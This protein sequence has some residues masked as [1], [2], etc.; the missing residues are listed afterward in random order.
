MKK[1]VPYFGAEAYIA[2]WGLNVAGDQHSS[3][4]MWVQ[5]GP[6]DQLNVILAGWTVNF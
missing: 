2:G 4:N 5:N 1:G 3:T 6:P